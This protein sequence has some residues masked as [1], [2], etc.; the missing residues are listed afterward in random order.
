VPFWLSPLVA[1]AVSTALRGW[2]FVPWANQS[3]T[4]WLHPAPSAG[5]RVNWA[6]AGLIAALY[7]LCLLAISQFP[8]A[9]IP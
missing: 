8:P 2:Y 9:L 6:G 3:L 1:N 4:W 7:A 5:P